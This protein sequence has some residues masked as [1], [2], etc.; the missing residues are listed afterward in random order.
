MKHKS[1]IA[2]IG[3]AVMGENLA[4]NLASK[5]FQVIVYSRNEETVHQFLSSRAQGKPIR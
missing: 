2:L 3:I 5:G 1:D 4:L